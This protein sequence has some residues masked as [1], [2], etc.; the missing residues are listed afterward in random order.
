MSLPRV[1]IAA[2][3]V[4]EHDRALAA[5]AD[6]DRANEPLARDEL[7]ARAETAVAIVA[8]PGQRVDAELL[9]HAPSLRLVSNHAVGLDN[10]DLEACRA[11]G[12]MVTNTPGVLTEATADL[13]FGLVIDA[14][15]R[16]SEGDRQVRAGQWKGWTPTHHLGRR[17]HGATLGIVGFGRIGRAVARRARG[18]DMRVL[19]ASPH[20]VEGE[21]ATRVELD[22]LLEESDVV[23]LHAPLN[24]R[25]RGLLSRQRL[26]RMKRG[27]I[28]V[29]TARGPLV[30]E[31]ALAELLVGGHLGGAALDVFVGEP[32]I[33]PVL[34]AAPRL[35]LSPHIGSADTIARDA[36]AALACDAVRAFLVGEAPKNR[37]V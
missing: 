21:P 3:L 33:D 1:L 27:A 32:A 13:A 9:E 12:V 15:R 29:N 5:I 2:P 10:V 20:A 19:Y 23:S 8:I 22:R 24:E 26:E 31:R 18:F 30:D 4:G 11:R 37:V 14:C 17:V 36:M 34:L 28:L 16:I 25:T 6:L 35:V 7:L